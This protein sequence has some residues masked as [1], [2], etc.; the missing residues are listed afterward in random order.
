MSGTVQCAVPGHFFWK[1]KDMGEERKEWPVKLPSFDFS[2]KTVVVTGGTKGIGCAIAMAFARCRANVV[3]SSRHQSDCMETAQTI[4]SYGGCAEGICADVR[5]V[6]EIARLME[7]KRAQI[8]RDRYTGK[9][10]RY[11]GYKADRG[12]GRRRL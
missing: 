9:L 10:R 4:C 12:S 1:E 11:S 5:Q 7:K 8:R 2:G 3:V 6:S